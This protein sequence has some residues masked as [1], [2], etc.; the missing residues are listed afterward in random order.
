MGRRIHAV[1]AVLISAFAAGCQPASPLPRDVAAVFGGVGLA[2]GLFNYPRS[3]AA[4]PRGHVFVVDKSG[5]IQ[6]FSPKGSFEVG[7]RMPDTR[8]GYPVGLAVHP[9]GRLFVADTHCH[10]VMI[11]DREGNWLGSFGSEGSGDGQF[12]LPTDVA[13]DSEGFIYVSEYHQN[14]R[15]SRWSPELRFV[16]SFG[17]TPIDGKRLSRPTGLV[18]DDEDTLWVADA[19]HHRLIRFDSEGRVLAVFGRFGEKPGEMRYPYDISLSPE[20][21]L[22]VCEYEGARLQWFSKDGRSLRVWGRHGRRP[23]EMFAPWGAVYG[24]QGRV[25]VVDSLNNRVQVVEP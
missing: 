21:T 22:M 11:Y 7:W 23:G 3:I 20:K 6:R 5:R 19:C 13:F 12:Q 15:I 24:P 2:W 10:R 18:V 9:D 4:D 25:Y 1:A 16:R 8:F 17:E 14:D